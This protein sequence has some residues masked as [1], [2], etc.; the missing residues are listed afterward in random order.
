M[1]AKQICFVGG[2]WEKDQIQSVIE[3]LPDSLL[4][5]VSVLAAEMR[6]PLGLGTEEFSLWEVEVLD[7]E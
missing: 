2:K 3:E 4:E 5:E 6:V 1:R 7:G